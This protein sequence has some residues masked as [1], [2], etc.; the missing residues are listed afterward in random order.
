MM[1]HMV[2][3]MGNYPVAHRPARGVRKETTLWKLELFCGHSVLRTESRAFVKHVNCKECLS[4]R[5]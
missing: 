3:V 4:R 5:D 1:R 2:E